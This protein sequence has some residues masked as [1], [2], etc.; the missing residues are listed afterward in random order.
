MPTG[1]TAI[2]SVTAVAVLD[3]WVEHAEMLARRLTSARD[4]D[5]LVQLAPE[6]RAIVAEM[7]EEDVGGGLITRMVSALNDALALRVIALVTR[8]HRLPSV[9][10][11]WIALGSEGRGEQTLLTDQDNGIVYAAADAAE[12]RALRPLLLAYAAEVNQVLAS[13]GFKLCDGGIM[14]GNPDCCLSLVEWQER[15]FSWVRTPEPPALLNATIYFDLRALYGDDTLV[16]TLRQHLTRITAGADAFLRMM[17]ENALAAEPPLGFLRDFAAKDGLVDL[18]KHG[19]RI[20][21]D[22]AR[23]LSLASPASGTVLRL[24][25]AVMAGSLPEGDARAAIGAFQYLQRVR[26]QAQSDALS[27]NQPVT[28]LIDPRV[29]TEF[30]R[31]ML[32]EAFKQAKLLQQRLKITFRIEG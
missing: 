9:S 12:A 7:L 14:A 8:H 2:S 23:I 1:K 18:K 6:T 25:H 26:L 29:L 3:P 32:H 4:V 31:P 13:C 28:N 17:A 19:A 5:T 27:V 24:R 22:A 16:R 20:F 11:C 15:F 30:D 21:V 10:W